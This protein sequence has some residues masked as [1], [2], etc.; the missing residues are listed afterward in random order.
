MHNVL[1]MLK[2]CLLSFV[3][4]FLLELVVFVVTVTNKMYNPVK[5]M[6]MSI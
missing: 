3:L 5:C 1:H 4:V 2:C 6:E